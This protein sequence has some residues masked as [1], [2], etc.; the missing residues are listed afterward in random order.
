[1]GD[2]RGKQEADES[3]NKLPLEELLSKSVKN[4]SGR[5]FS[6]TLANSHVHLCR[7]VL[8]S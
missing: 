8:W 5:G 7:I 6:S 3:Q 4:I 1:M 2:G